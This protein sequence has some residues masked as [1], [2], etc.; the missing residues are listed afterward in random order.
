MLPG[1]PERAP[2][3]AHAIETPNFLRRH[4]PAEATPEVVELARRSDVLELADELGRNDVR[5]VPEIATLT[6][7][8]FEALFT[9]EGIGL[10]VRALP[11]RFEVLT[12][13]QRRRDR[14]GLG[15]VRHRGGPG[16]LYEGA[17]GCI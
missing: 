3:D 5:P 2:A 7:F 11:A 1:L 14:E 17:A 4:N 15:L 16:V 6:D 13:S 9:A 10:G 12:G 8:D